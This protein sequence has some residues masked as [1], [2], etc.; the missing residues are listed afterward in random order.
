M[1]DWQ[2]IATPL[3]Q[4][5]ESYRA[6]AY[7][8]PAGVW[9]IGWG[10][11]GADIKRGTTWTLEQADARFALDLAAFGAGVERL[12]KQPATAGEMAAMVSLAYNIGLRAFGRSTLLR[13]FNAGDKVGAAAQFSAWTK[14]RD[15]AGKLVVLRGLV[16]RR[17]D[18]AR[19]FRGA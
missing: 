5:W 4:R 14:A 13:K 15:K 12:L 7:L 10:S 2:S 3:I 16:A 9:T 17:E 1:S 8:C 6:S 19:V 11:T 18:E